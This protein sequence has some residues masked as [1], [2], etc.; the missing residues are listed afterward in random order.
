MKKI[1][2]CLLSF[3]LFFSSIMPAWAVGAEGAFPEKTF[4]AALERA[5]ALQTPENIWV[6]QPHQIE[7]FLRFQNADIFAEL[8]SYPQ[9]GKYL[10]NDLLESCYSHAVSSAVKGDIWQGKVSTNNWQV[11]GGQYLQVCLDMA[12]RYGWD[13]KAV[14]PDALAKHYSKNQNRLVVRQIKEVG[15]SERGAARAYLYLK[16]LLQIEDVCDKKDED[17]SRLP[18]ESQCEVAA[19]ALEALAVIAKQ[20]PDYQEKSAQAIYDFMV[21]KNRSKMGQAAV[22]QGALLL[23]ALG[24]HRKLK[25]FLMEHARQT[26]GGRFLHHLSYVSFEGIAKAT[27]ENQDHTQG[28]YLNS[29]TSRYSYLDVDTA[30]KWYP[31]GVC[32]TYSTAVHSVRNQYQCPYGNL[33]EDLGA[34]IAQDSAHAQT[35]SLAHW[36]WQQRSDMPA[37]L[38]TGLL[39]G[40][41]GKWTYEM[42]GTEAQ[43]QLY[44]LLTADYTDLNEGT[45]RRMKIAAAEALES[46]RVKNVKSADY[47]QRDQQKFDRYAQQQWSRSALGMLDMTVAL[48]VLPRLLLSLGTLGTRGVAA[49]AKMTHIRKVQ[50]WGNQMTKVLR[51]MNGYVGAS[52]KAVASAKAKPSPVPSATEVLQAPKTQGLAEVVPL[53]A[54]QQ[55]SATGE[56]SMKIVL[57]EEKAA[58]NLVR[59]QAEVSKFSLA[60]KQAFLNTYR[61]HLAHQYQLARQAGT[62]LTLVQREDAYYKAYQSIFRAQQEALHSAEL[63]ALARAYTATA[64]KPGRVIRHI[65]W[66]IRAEVWA[67]SLW[68]DVKAGLKGTFTDPR[69]FGAMMGVTGVANPAFTINT[70]VTAATV[71]GLPAPFVLMTDFAG[72][73]GSKLTALRSTV[74]PGLNA[75]KNLGMSV[76]S[77]PISKSM[78]SPFL[79]GVYTFAEQVGPKLLFPA[80]VAVFTDQF[81]NDVVLNAYRQTPF[82]AETLFGLWGQ[83]ELLLNGAETTKKKFDTRQ[84]QENLLA[85]LNAGF[86]Y[87]AD[88]ARNLLVSQKV[89]LIAEIA[90]KQALSLSAGAEEAEIERHFREILTTQLTEDLAYYR[91]EIFDVLGWKNL[92]RQVAQEQ[93]ALWRPQI[94]QNVAQRQA[95][96]DQW[97][98]I[99]MPVEEFLRYEDLI[100]SA[101]KAIVEYYRLDAEI[102]AI[103]KRYISK[104]KYNPKERD[105]PSVDMYETKNIFAVG[106]RGRIIEKY[107]ELLQS[108]IEQET[109]PQVIKVLEEKRKQA[110]KWHDAV[111]HSWVVP[112]DGTSLEVSSGL[113]KRL[114]E[115]AAHKASFSALQT[116]EF[117]KLEEDLYSKIYFSQEEIIPLQSRLVVFP[118][119]QKTAHSVFLIGSAFTSQDV[120]GRKTFLGFDNPVFAQEVS[121]EEA[122]KNFVPNQEN[123]LL[124]HAHGGLTRQ[125]VWKAPLVQDKQTLFA[126]HSITTE[127]LMKQLVKTNSARTSVYVNACFS[128]QII[129]EVKSTPI[130]RQYASVL[131]HTD[132]YVTA[133]KNQRTMP[134][135]LPAEWVQ[136][137]TRQKLLNKVLQRMRFNGDGLAARVWIDGREIYPLQESVKRLE[138]ERKSTGLNREKGRL[139]KDLRLLLAMAEAPTQKKLM[140]AV[141]RFEKAYPWLVFYLG[142]SQKHP[143]AVFGWGID[144]MEYYTQKFHFPF[145]TLEQEWV[146]YVA[147]VAE[148][149]FST[150]PEP[151]ALTEAVSAPEETARDFSGK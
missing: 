138:A 100:P 27:H 70:T 116:E 40:G 58:A 50:V 74:A 124:V 110:V 79:S 132:F 108:Q 136:G 62:K 57:S 127:E 125:N 5:V 75:P 17:L 65:P 119:A 16:G 133:S 81:S 86:L 46:N 3:C 92:A 29:Y 118:K 33:Y 146:D 80:G 63:D 8:S 6:S 64:W 69:G 103:R 105:L 39:L 7:N 151:P 148:E 78:V 55:I 56:A 97:R 99:K 126:L 141:K 111:V 42:G 135:V 35:A 4:S 9:D 149:L 18:H 143:Y 112:S 94:E 139:L 91:A 45:Q 1:L 72:G 28:A 121:V 54:S 89:A 31:R 77:S 49:V 90:Y 113:R 24:R 53:P 95:I 43:E 13:G 25:N 34:V 88:K 47:A 48:M 32:S 114:R 37:P 101:T 82:I 131:E 22:F 51:N 36:I 122:L 15:V 93:M 11:N 10:M 2:S 68:S 109:D 38:V 41:K 142:D 96:V 130:Q 128:G 98:G 60:D 66:K 12:L 20:H 26:G 30:D 147:S 145:I 120:W 123:I 84:F 67:S 71:R 129:N 61:T 87:K 85:E 107:H 117:A 104:S 83:E 102:S 144:E 44:A 76:W 137:S 19:D 23:M 21:E 115:L 73:M 14:E 52:S 59:M 106:F 150:V 140:K 134:E